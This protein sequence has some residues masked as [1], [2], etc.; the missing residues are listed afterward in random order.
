MS[1]NARITAYLGVLVCETLATASNK[2]CSL[3]IDNP[4]RIGQVFMNTKETLGVSEEAIELLKK[5]PIGRDSIGDVDWFE[6]S[7]Q[8]D[9]FG[10]LGG[11][12]TI[13]GPDLK[14]LE[15]ARGFRIRSYV[16]IPNDVPEDA[17][18][19]IDSMKATT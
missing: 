1:L 8:G 7:A 10:W 2:D 15:T 11:P 4:N 13:K 5:I 18:A 12:K 16:S 14:E 6:S 17:K 3:S 19:Y 9:V